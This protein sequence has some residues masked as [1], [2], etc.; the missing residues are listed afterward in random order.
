MVSKLFL[1]VWIFIQ[2]LV[3]SIM[4]VSLV[5]LILRFAYPPEGGAPEG[6]APPDNI[7]EILAFLGGGLLFGLVLGIFMSKRIYDE[8]LSTNP[9]QD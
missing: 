8:Y 9:T 4:T 1:W 7:Y 5:A 2:P 6:F 3:I